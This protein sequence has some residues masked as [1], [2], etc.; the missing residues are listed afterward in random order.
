M[1]KYITF[2][3]RDSEGELQYYILQRQFPHIVGEISTRPKE[4]I[5]QPIQI[6]GYYLWLTLNGTLQGFLLPDYINIQEEIKFVINDMAIWYYANRIVPE[7]KKYKK[8]KYDS[9][10]NQ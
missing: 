10:S 8:F 4:F 3:E 7:H 5:V 2:R 9:S 1:E 6:T